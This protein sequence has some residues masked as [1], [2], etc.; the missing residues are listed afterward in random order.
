MW[1]DGAEVVQ[2]AHSGGTMA[3]G[4]SYVTW[5]ITW[6][7]LDPRPTFDQVK[8]YLVRMG[9]EPHLL[10]DPETGRIAQFIAADR[11]ARALVNQTG[12]IE[13]NRYGAVNL[14]IETYFSPGVNGGQVFTDNPMVGLERIMAFADELGIPRVAPFTFSMPQRDPLALAAC[15]GGHIGHMHWPENHHT[16]PGHIDIQE[17]LAT[18]GDD[19]PAPKDWDDADWAAFQAKTEKVVEKL[20]K[21]K[22]W[23]EA[24]LKAAIEEVRKLYDDDDYIE[25]MKAAYPGLN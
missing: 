22:T 5:H 6:D 23:N 10:W 1:L 19:M 3:G 13:T 8:T 7:K 14:Q 12:G 17:I 20:Y 18:G 24:L 11:S 4:D 15:G 9:Y 21:D 16:D 2:G 25:A